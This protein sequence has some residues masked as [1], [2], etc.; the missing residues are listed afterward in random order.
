MSSHMGFIQNVKSI[1]EYIF[2]RFENF[3]FLHYWNSQLS[4]LDFDNS[5]IHW[6]DGR[7]MK[8]SDRPLGKFRK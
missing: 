1:L 5:Q 2:F 8:L 6:D 4:S 3:C 7:L